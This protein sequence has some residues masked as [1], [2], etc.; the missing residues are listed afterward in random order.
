MPT[1]KL[2]ICLGSTIRNYSLA[3][4]AVTE[5]AAHLLARLMFR[6]LIFTFQHVAIKV[7]H[8]GQSFSCLAEFPAAGHVLRRPSYEWRANRLPQPMIWSCSLSRTGAHPVNHRAP[9]R[10]C[11]GQVKFVEVFYI[12]HH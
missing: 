5:S 12:H 4:R 11:Q 7:T 2:L 9:R 3:P 1:A 10:A 6:G 8:Q